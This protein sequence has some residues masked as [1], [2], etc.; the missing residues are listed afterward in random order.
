MEAKVSSPDAQVF[1]A[2]KLDG[3]TTMWKTKSQVN[4]IEVSSASIHMSSFSSPRA[5][6]L[7]SLSDT[8]VDSSSL[9]WTLV[10]KCSKPPVPEVAA[11]VEKHLECSL[12][13]TNFW[14]EEDLI[15]EAQKLIFE[16]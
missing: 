3:K 8:E 9:G 13:S 11:V 7:P 16:T 12:T 15:I 10:A 4:S 5:K 14:E 1:Q 2:K 6:S